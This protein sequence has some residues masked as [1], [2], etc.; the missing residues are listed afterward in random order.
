MKKFFV[1]FVAV[2]LTFFPVSKAQNY[3]L[4]FN[5]ITTAD[6]ISQNYVVCA[7]QDSKGFMWFGTQDG[8][9]RYDGYNFKVYK[10]IPN[11]KTS[12]SENWIWNIYEDSKGYLWIG[13]F[14][15]GACRFDRIT[16]TFKTYRNDPTDS[17]SISH[18]TVWAFYEAPDGALWIGTNN[19]L[20]LFN[21][22]DETFTFFEPPGQS[23]NVFNVLPLSDDELIMSTHEALLIFNIEDKEFQRIEHQPNNI[24]SIGKI[25]SSLVT[26]TLGI[27]WAGSS[28]DGLNRYDPVNNSVKRYYKNSADPDNSLA[29]NDVND[30]YAD[31]QGN[32]WAATSNGLSLMSFSGDKLLS[33]HNFYNDLIDPYSI[34]G[35]YLSNIYESPSGEIWISGRD[36][37]NRFERNNQKFEHR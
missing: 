27:F 2:A 19:G 4:R 5:R 1:F 23:K 32:I 17:N 15:G 36:A 31:K 16:E 30:V 7:Y 21:S 26:D 9:N 13:T 34:S 14:G 25:E 33:A 37:L 22:E 29:Q 11:D 12:L 35:N 3:N 6:G 24:K 28:N 20:D 8:L 10:H 18:N